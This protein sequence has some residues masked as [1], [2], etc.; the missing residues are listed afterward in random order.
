MKRFFL[1]SFSFSLSLV[2][3]GQNV[4]VT[5]DSLYTADPSAMLDVKSA[6]KGFLMPRLTTLQRTGMINPAAG[7][8]V[9]DADEN[10][11]YYYNGTEWLDVS[12]GGSGDIWMI[13]GSNVH[14]TDSTNNVGV[15][16]STPANKFSV[17][18]NPDTGADEAIFSVVGP[19]GDTLFA[20]YPEGTRVYVKDDPA[21][22]GGNKAGFA[23]GGFSLSKGLTNE[24]LRVTPDSVRVYIEDTTGLKASGN[25]GGF[26][27]GGFSLSKGAN[28]SLYMFSDRTGF[29]VTYLTQAERDAITN[30]R[31]S[32]LIFNITDSCL[33]IFLGYWESIWCTPIGC[34]YPGIS[35]PPVNDTI[36][37]SGENIS[38]SV[39][40]TGSKLYYKWQES[41]DGGSTWEMLSDGGTSPNYSGVHSNILSM[42]NVPLDYDGYQYRCLI[43]NACGDILTDAA[44]L[45][46]WTCGIHKLTD[47][48]D[49]HGYNTVLINNQCW[50][51]ENLNIGTMIN[52]T[53]PGQL[54]T[55]NSVIEKYCYGNNATDCNTY[56]GLYEW[57]EMMQYNSSDAG[58]PGATQGICPPGWHLPTDAEWTVLTDYLGGLTVAGG[59][60]KETGTVHWNSP[61]TGADNSSGFTG[62]PGGSRDY[63][64]GLFYGLGESSDHWSATESNST[65]AW[66]RYMYYDYA[67]VNSFFYEKTNGFSVRCI[68]DLE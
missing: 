51:A 60:M 36:I 58:N 48:R 45:I 13:S 64:D 43:I 15:G 3:S 28:D 18:A 50:M 9:Y 1:F 8:M 24:Y 21:K 53:A 66:K 26:A 23:V 37:N 65:R 38:F 32:S 27:V 67:D 29:N 63:W 31:M 61:N 6:N 49:S 52:S 25:R 22:A 39:S 68:K 33:Q 11:F 5:D 19:D 34:M 30:P 46:K 16:T 42:T 41:I 47:V 7:L 35:V 10:V 4:A 57:Y 55:D 59:K 62:L 12:S 56:G 14:L 20:V 2:L 44:S 40:A 54:Q 17:Q